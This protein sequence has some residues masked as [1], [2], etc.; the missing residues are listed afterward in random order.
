MK[1]RN[2]S[3]IQINRDEQPLALASPILVAASTVAGSVIKR[4]LA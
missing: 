3:F 1:S 2:C 4:R